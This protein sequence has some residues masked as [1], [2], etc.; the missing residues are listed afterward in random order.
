[1]DTNKNSYT[2]IYATIM[3]VIVAA[4]L[5]FAS[6]ALKGKQE[7]NVA[8]EKQLN[9]LT[10]V[11]LAED[12]AHA[13]DKNSYV[14]KE[15]AKYIKTSFILNYKGEKIDGDAFGVNLKEQYDLMKKIDAASQSDGKVSE[16]KI[17]GMKAQLRLPVFVCITNDGKTADIF[18][19]Y[20]TGLWGP[21]WGYLSI[22]DDFNTIKGAVFDD[23]GETPGLG[24][25][26]AERSFQ[27]QF[28]GKEIFKGD[29]FTSITLKKGGATQANIKHEVD[30]ISG[31]TMTSRGLNKA[32]KQWLEY[33]LPYIKAKKDANSSNL[34]K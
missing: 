20:G 6:T 26:I 14:E 28:A 8:V 29:A 12:A 2:I 31:G 21:I 22:A 19:C 16:Q 13:A 33:Y 15:Y 24:G 32:I 1:M 10:S 18:S 3:V 7:R 17:N 11:N 30:A 25:E 23:E 9:L 4:V 27:M 34:S 5:A